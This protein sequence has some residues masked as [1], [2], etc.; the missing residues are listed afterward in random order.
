MSKIYKMS[1]KSNTAQ[2]KLASIN[3]ITEETIAA[4]HAKN[5]ALLPNFCLSRAQIKRWFWSWIKSEDTLTIDESFAERIA[6]QQAHIDRSFKKHPGLLTFKSQQIG[7]MYTQFGENGYVE[8][9][10]KEHPPLKMRPPK[11][12]LMDT[13]LQ[14]KFVNQYCVERCVTIDEY[15]KIWTKLDLSK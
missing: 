7:T 10:T 1:N 13:K 3:G 6:K 5:V 11:D 14:Q 4:Y 2:T 9:V 15:D 8:F 12:T